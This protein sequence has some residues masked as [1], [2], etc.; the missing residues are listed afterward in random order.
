MKKC[1]MCE[2]QK[3]LILSKKVNF[4]FSISPTF[5]CSLGWKCIEQLNSPALDEWVNR[6]YR[7][8]LRVLWLF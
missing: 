1:L 8:N 2:Q 3:D 5:T 4:L 6:N 7:T